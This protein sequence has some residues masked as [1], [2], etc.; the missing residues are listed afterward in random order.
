MELIAIFIVLLVFAVALVFYVLI[1][2]D[3]DSLS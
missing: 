3:K 2:G 1:K